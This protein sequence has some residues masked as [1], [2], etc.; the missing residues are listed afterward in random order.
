MGRFFVDTGDG[1]E[2][3]ET[4]QDAK[5][6]AQKALD[7]WREDARTSGEWPDEIAEVCWGE[8]K[9]V[10]N[11]TDAG[12]YELKSEEA[13]RV[14]AAESGMLDAASEW[15]KAWRIIAQALKELR[16]PDCDGNARAII[17]RLAAENMLI[18][19]ID[20]VKG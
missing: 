8:V 16:C 7:Y 3:C 4:E 10:A 15:T 5:Q 19:G 11:M 20:N 1:I 14:A 17:A 13:E 9:Q 18:V 12:E 6:Q 2:F